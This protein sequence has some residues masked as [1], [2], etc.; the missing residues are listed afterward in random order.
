MK[1]LFILIAAVLSL[2]YSLVA[3]ELDSTR[4]VVLVKKQIFAHALSDQTKQSLTPKNPAK[5]M[6]L[7][8]AHT[9]I[10]IGASIALFSIGDS[11]VEGIQLVTATSLLVYGGLIGPSVGN[12]YAKD[13]ARGGIGMGLRAAGTLMV[14]GHI[15]ETIRYDNDDDATGGAPGDGLALL[16]TALVMGSTFWNILSARN[17]ANAYNKKYGLSGISFGYD[18]ITKK[19]SVGIGFKF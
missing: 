3:G 14:F 8:L 10:P 7:A 13:Y 15:V 9:L 18:P 16:G 5:A 19:T 17:S 6:N 1:L 4:S 2:N 12:F 11:N